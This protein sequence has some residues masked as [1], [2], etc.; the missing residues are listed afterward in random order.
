MSLQTHH[1]S[2]HRNQNIWHTRAEATFLFPVDEEKAEH[3]ESAAR[4]VEARESRH[5]CLIDDGEA[6]LQWQVAQEELEH[7][8]GVASCASP[9]DGLPPD[10]ELENTA[11]LAR[12]I[13]LTRRLHSR[14][15]KELVRATVKVAMDEEHAR[16]Q[17][18]VFGQTRA[19]EAERLEKS[20]RRCVAPPEEHCHVY[21]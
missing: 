4:L 5:R 13:R 20:S 8:P 9:H 18:S 19:R 17:G 2:R 14:T 16:E 12:L 15:H 1:D 3:A 6:R 7:A 21:R 10:H 11:L